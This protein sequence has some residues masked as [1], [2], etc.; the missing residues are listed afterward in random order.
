MKKDGCPKAPGRERLY[1]RLRSTLC[2]PQV[3][4]PFSGGGQN[5]PVRAQAHPVHFFIS[6]VSL[7]PGPKNAGTNQVG[8]RKFITRGREADSPSIPRNP[9][10]QSNTFDLQRSAFV[11]S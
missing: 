4:A 10:R 8:D 9:E 11:D 3:N 7:V 2:V 6:G 1:T 5:Q